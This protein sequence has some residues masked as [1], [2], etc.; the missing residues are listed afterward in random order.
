MRRSALIS[1]KFLVPWGQSSASAMTFFW[2]WVLMIRSQQ[3]HLLYIHFYHHVRVSLMS[4]ACISRR[5]DVVLYV[6]SRRKSSCSSLHSPLGLR[7]FLV[8]SRIQ[9]SFITHGRFIHN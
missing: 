2:K 1:L 3:N 9:S 7:A 8:V 6:L 5:A 4:A